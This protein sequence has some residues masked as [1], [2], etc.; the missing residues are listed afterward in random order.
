MTFKKTLQAVSAAALI[1]LS[2]QVLANMSTIN[3]ATQKSIEVAEGFYRDVLVYRNLNNYG[4]YIGDTYIQHATAYG[5]GPV[6][7]IKAIASELTA[8]PEVKVELYRTIAED[9]YVAIHSLWTTSSGDKYVYVDIWREQDGKLVEHWDH[10]QQVPEQ[11]ANANTMY[12][13]PAV[14]IYA[15]Q[16]IEQ[17]PRESGCCIEQ[18]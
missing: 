5:D 16:D 12:Q 3:Q 8:D 2:G 14:N 10:Y 1:T 17:N 15:K 4:K 6:E 9:D 18:L 7:L 13:G 11:S